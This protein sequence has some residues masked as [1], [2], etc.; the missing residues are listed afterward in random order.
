MVSSD[1]L[2]TA[3]LQVDLGVKAGL[4]LIV[5]GFARSVLSVSPPDGV[6]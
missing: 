6:C 4:A 1:T 3:S 5:I 2:M